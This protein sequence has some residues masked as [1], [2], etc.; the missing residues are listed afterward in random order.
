MNNLQSLSSSLSLSLPPLPIS[1]SLFLSLYVWC[2]AVGIYVRKCDGR[3]LLTVTS[4]A[5]LEGQ[6]WL[7]PVVTSYKSSSLP[8]TYL[9]TAQL[10]VYSGLAYEKLLSASVYRRHSAL[11]FTIFFGITQ[12]SLMPIKT[13]SV[14]RRELAVAACDYLV[15]ASV[16]FL[17]IDEIAYHCYYLMIIYYNIILYFLML[18]IVKPILF[19]FIISIIFLLC[20]CY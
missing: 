4:K 8:S 9:K 17:F 11:M 3:T 5:D 15:L 10:N 2:R 7:P 1:L 16:S 6:I 13:S 12:I 14:F 18:T 19:N 20:F